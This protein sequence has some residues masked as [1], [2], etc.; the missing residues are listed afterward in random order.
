M[1]MTSSQICAVLVL[2][3]LSSPSMGQTDQPR[4]STYDECITDSMRGVGSDV[5]A[6]A[7]IS[8]CRNQFPEQVATAAAQEEVAPGA[9]RSLT[10]EELG[11]LAATAFVTGSTYRMTFRNGNDDLTLTEVTIAVWSKS[12]PDGRREYTQKVRIG[13]LESDSAKY[14]VEPRATGFDWSSTYE[15]D[16]AWVVAAAKG[17]D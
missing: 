11:K 3:V 6:N 17:I 12:N 5:A 7:I 1:K 10:P 9:S 14:A 2:A 13:P 8:S 15:D 4:P 16:S